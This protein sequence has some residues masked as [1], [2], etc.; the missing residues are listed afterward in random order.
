MKTPENHP[1]TTR[2]ALTCFGPPHDR[3]LSATRSFIAG[4]VCLLIAACGG[5]GGQAS[6]AETINLENVVDDKGSGNVGD[7]VSEGGADVAAPVVADIV[8]PYVGTWVSDC[9]GDASQNPPTYQRLSFKLTKVSAQSMDS[10]GR[11]E[12]FGT[13]STCGANGTLIASSST[14]V[15]FTGQKTLTDGNVVDRVKVTEKTTDGTAGDIRLD[16]LFIQGHTLYPGDDS[17]VDAAAEYPN[18]LDRRIAFT[19]S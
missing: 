15:A 6:S 5:G 12:S 1:T 17:D 19:R 4:A 14:L 16:I 3:F 7:V 18:A 11:H 13:D 8:D 10:E 2:N 9:A